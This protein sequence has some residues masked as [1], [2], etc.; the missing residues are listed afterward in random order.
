M[1]LVVHTERREMY[2]FIALIRNLR[3]VKIACSNDVI[4]IQIIS[5]G[6]HKNISYCPQWLTLSI[7]YTVQTTSVP[8]ERC[9]S[10]RT[11]EFTLMR[12]HNLHAVHLL[13]KAKQI[14]LCFYVNFMV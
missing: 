10:G 13:W 2:T 4:I 12:G 3:H 8:F 1:R 7:L 5:G 9:S 14:N 11:V 6:V